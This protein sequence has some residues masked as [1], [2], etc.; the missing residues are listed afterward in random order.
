[1]KL[2]V[3]ILN[4]N[5]KYF[6]ELCL[7][8]VQDA[9]AIIDSEIIVVDNKSE[10]GSCDMVK[11]LFPEVK[12]IENKNNYG[13]SKGNNIGVAE[14]KGEYLCILNP[15]T[16]V[17]EDTF[18]KLLEF[19]ESKQNLG[20]VGCKLI[21]GRGS[22]LPESKRKIPFVKAS[23][24]KI[25]GNTNDYYA[26]NIDK[27]AIG[28]VDILVGAFMFLKK[29]T[30]NKIEGFDED[31]FMYG[32]DIDI[33]YK[34]LK[35]GLENYYFGE[36]TVLHYKGES[37]LRNKDYA[38]RFYGAMQI[39]Y[40]K[41]FK[42]NVFFDL[43]VWGGIKVVYW[44]RK[45]P[46]KKHKVV[47]EYVFLSDNKNKQL[48]SVLNKALILK[49]DVKNIV[50]ESEVIFDANALSYKNI[51]NFMEAEHLDD[52]VTFKILPK[53]SKFVIGSDDAISRGEIINF[54]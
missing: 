36:T 4:Y 29:E 44:F 42:K 20:I 3:V 18:I 15:D 46:I 21:D 9:V 50:K 26:N 16:V 51:I 33:S 43:F 7:K 25:L 8:S 54:D 12:L 31:Y 6:L 19:A 49:S 27:N 11:K 48:E 1:M 23:L 17:A 52:S 53:N 28:K 35:Q 40:K 5:V 2:S 22:F 47:K 14:A 38:R 30:Y 37:T 13:F 32:E 24:K 45:Q 39:F 41:H 34:A 10:D